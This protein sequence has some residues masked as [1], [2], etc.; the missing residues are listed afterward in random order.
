MIHSADRLTVLTA[1]EPGKLATKTIRM[2]DG[3]LAI[4]PYDKAAWF[5]VDQVPVQDLVTLGRALADFERRPRAFV[6]RGAP[7]PTTNLSR[8]RR[9]IY[10]QV[11]EDG[12]LVPETFEAAARRWLALDFDDLPTPTWNEEDLARR[13][14]AIVHDRRSTA[15]RC[16]RA[17]TMAKTSI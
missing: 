8:C 5:R 16:P 11:E 17:R 9:L 4:T 10:P 6:I 14:E 12:E 7:L 3:E 13:R 1:V 2:V 15:C